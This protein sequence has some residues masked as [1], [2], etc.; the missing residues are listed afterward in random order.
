MTAS[1][2][3]SHPASTNAPSSPVF[4]AAMIGRTMGITGRI[5]DR[6]GGG[7][8]RQRLFSV[9]VPVLTTK[10]KKKKN[11]KTSGFVET[12]TVSESAGNGFS[13]RESD[14]RV[15]F[16]RQGTTVCREIWEMG[17]ER[18]E[19]GDRRRERGEGGGSGGGVD[20]KY[21]L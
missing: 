17:N 7:S 16:I 18:W 14:L 21:L 3:R 13:P 5:V 12:S 11:T 15:P 20:K 8:P 4:P 6:G 2:S 1:P 9:Q 10:S 19:I